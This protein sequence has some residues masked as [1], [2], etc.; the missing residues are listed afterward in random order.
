LVV[1]SVFPDR[2]FL[3]FTHDLLPGFGEQALPYGTYLIQSAFR[4]LG[5]EEKV[6]SSPHLPAN[7]SSRV[8]VII[9]RV[10][11]PLANRT[12]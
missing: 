5:G 8:T 7:A 11:H 12:R 4:A 6:M 1:D 3:R 2:V 9:L 10:Q